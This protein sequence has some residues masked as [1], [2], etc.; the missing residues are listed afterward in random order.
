MLVAFRTSRDRGPGCCFRTCRVRATALYALQMLSARANLS[1]AL[2]LAIVAATGLALFAASRAR[3]RIA[4]VVPVL[5]GVA[6]AVPTMPR[7]LADA[8]VADRRATESSA[9][10]TNPRCASPRVHSHALDQ[11]RGP[12]RQALAILA[13]KLPP[14]PTRVVVETDGNRTRGPRRRT[15]S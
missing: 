6:I 5:L 1:Q 3:T 11:L 10:P 14:A 12:A 7:Q 4:A 13:A 15:R 2:W 9:P 8:W